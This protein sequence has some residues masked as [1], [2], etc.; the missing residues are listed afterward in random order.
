VTISVW[1]DV[2]DVAG[3]SRYGR[4]LSEADSVEAQRIRDPAM[5]LSLIASRALLRRVATEFG[6]SLPST[7]PRRC[8]ACGS[9]VHGPP[10]LADHL[11]T[12]I[13]RRTTLVAVAVSDRPVGIDVEDREAAIPLSAAVFSDDER[14]WLES[15]SSSDSVW[16]WTAK[17]AVGKLSGWGLIGADAVGVSPRRGSLWSE[18]VTAHG[19]AAVVR[20]LAATSRHVMTL[21]SYVPSTVR[22]SPTSQMEEEGRPF[23]QIY[24]VG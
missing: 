9:R 22:I 13:S 20:E 11:F 21:A 17:E 23:S 8:P 4:L 18:A 7:I 10:V 5:R 24:S 2:P 19:S 12:S 16:M 6:I 1:I 14:R 3:S 15:A